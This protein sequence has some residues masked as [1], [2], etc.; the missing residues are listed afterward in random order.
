M[1]AEIFSSRAGRLVPTGMF[2]SI[3]SSKNSILSVDPGFDYQD[4][5]FNDGP[6]LTKFVGGQ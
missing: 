4:E 3:S 5:D 1:L 6:A 2:M